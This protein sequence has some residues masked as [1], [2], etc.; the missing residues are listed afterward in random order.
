MSDRSH[1]RRAV[2][3]G[4]AAVGVS[5][6]VSSAFANGPNLPVNFTHGVA[7]GDPLANRVILWTRAFADGNSADFFVLWT[8][9]ERADMSS[10][11]AGGLISASA[12]N[13][14]CCKVDAQNLQPGKT[15]YYQFVYRNSRS[16]VG[17]TKTLPIGDVA[18]IKL[19]FF[20]CSNHPKGFFNVYREAAR[21]DDLNAVLHLGDY[22]YEYGPTGYA[23]PGLATGRNSVG[24]VVTQPRIEQLNPKNE[25]VSLADYRLRYALYR[26]D[27]DLQEL[28]RKNAWIT[29]WDDHESTNDS[30]RN[31]A[32]NHQTNEGPWENRVQASAKAYDEWM[33]I[34][35]AMDGNRLRIWRAFDFGNLA[36]L[37]MLD[38]R[39][40]GRDQYAVT[41]EQFLSFYLTAR[42]DG[43]F[44]ADVVPG[45]ATPRRI[46][47]VEQET[48]VQTQLSSSTQPWQIIGNQTLLHFQSAPN[49]ADTRVLP[50]TV[51]DPLLAGIQQL[52][53]GPAALAQYNQLARGGLPLYDFVADSWAAYPTARARFLTTLLQSARNPLVL[54]GDSHNSWAANLR[55]PT[56]TGIV[57]VGVEL[58]TPS[59]SSPG[60]EEALPTLPA[61]ALSAVILESNTAPAPTRVDQL[62]YADTAKRGFVLLDITRERAQAEWVL[63]NNVFS[64]TYTASTDRTLTVAAGARRFA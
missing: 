35:T 30:W 33:P 13:D 36:R 17:I 57:N 21:R 55:L 7:S 49:F 52:L 46:M 64:T 62:V 16:Q 24:Q 12:L 38:T 61:A 63:V 47:S 44:P 58:A 14:W 9:S 20:S 56:A 5:A 43:T 51:R 22:I 27:A 8:I 10:P 3:R 1:S 40:E 31:G 37:V 42:P 2:L 59:V 25:I 39:I 53:G 48:F 60:F 26:S 4:A 50:P 54:T 32:E 45:T 29:V 6:L 15:Y 28:H 23:T 18:N 11:V 34:R 19:A 41:Q